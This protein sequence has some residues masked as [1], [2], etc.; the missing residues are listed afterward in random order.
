MAHTSNTKE[1]TKESII[2]YD[3]PISTTPAVDKYGNKVQS[4]HENG[5]K[6]EEMLYAMIPPRLQAILSLRVSSKLNLANY[7]F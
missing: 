2:K 6:V 4:A 5:S 1:G 7:L 3:A